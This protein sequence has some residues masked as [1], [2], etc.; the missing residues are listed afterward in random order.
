RLWP[1]QRLSA[2][3]RPCRGWAQSGHIRPEIRERGTMAG[4]HPGIEKRGKRYTIRYRDADGAQHRES[5]GTYEEARDAKRRREQSVR[6]GS[7][8]DPAD[9]RVT[10]KAFGEDWRDR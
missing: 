1:G 4:R 7:F 8:V 3:P 5:F 9:H 10:V 6:D 2:R